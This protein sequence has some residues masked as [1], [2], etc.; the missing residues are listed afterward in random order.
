MKKYKNSYIY[1]SKDLDRSMCELS[2]YKAEGQ[3]PFPVGLGRERE[4]PHSVPPCT[5]V[6]K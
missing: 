3:F 2:N 5:K 6:K 4:V 1:W